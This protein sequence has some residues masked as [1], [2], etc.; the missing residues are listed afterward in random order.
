MSKAVRG[1]AGS[2]AEAEAFTDR[3]YKMN[4]INKTRLSGFVGLIL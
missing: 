1:I 4:R 3:I 2:I